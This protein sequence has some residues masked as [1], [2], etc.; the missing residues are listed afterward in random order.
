[1]QERRAIPRHRVFK[2]GSIEF[3]GASLDCTIRNL[4]PAGAA[5]DVE[6]SAGFPHEITLNIASRHTR[7]PAFVVW[8]RERRVGIMFAQDNTRWSASRPPALRQNEAT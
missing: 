8:R 6:S 5:L 2:A 3:D 1:M 7:R 4:S